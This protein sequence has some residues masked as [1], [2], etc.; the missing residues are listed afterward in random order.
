M[1][2]KVQKTIRLYFKLNFQIDVEH[3]HFFLLF[4]EC[5][6]LIWVFGRI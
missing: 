6:G 2:Y 1:Q 3:Q 5:D 4:H